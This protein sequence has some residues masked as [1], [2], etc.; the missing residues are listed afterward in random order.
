MYK[1]KKYKTK[2]LNLVGGTSQISR[3]TFPHELDDSHTNQSNSST[4]LS[5]EEFND[6]HT[7][8]SKYTPYIYKLINQPTSSPSSKEKNLTIRSLTEAS[9]KEK[10]LTK[11]SLT[12]AS[13]KEKKSEERYPTQAEADAILKEL[14][15]NSKFIPG[16]FPPYHIFRQIVFSNYL[17][18]NDIIRPFIPS[19]EKILKKQI[20][21]PEEYNLLKQFD[22]N[23]MPLS[24]RRKL[25][26]FFA[27]NE[28]IE[29]EQTS[30]MEWTPPII[31]NYKMTWVPK[32]K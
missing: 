9:S 26:S 32:E 11:R 28:I 24:E 10:K 6:S 23:F 15:D 8:Q 2:Y 7:D 13:L 16:N 29:G 20:I 5:Q 21:F 31:V 12:E 25:C 22:D 19:V 1:Y 30:Y 27:P 3:S 17:E 14:E 4:F 18:K